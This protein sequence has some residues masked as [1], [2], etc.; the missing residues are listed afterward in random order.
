MNGDI[1]GEFLL[2][3]KYKRT[4]AAKGRGRLASIFHYQTH[5]VQRMLLFAHLILYLRLYDVVDDII[6]S[7]QADV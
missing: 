3:W 1:L 5:S 2:L 6:Q 7:S 4:K